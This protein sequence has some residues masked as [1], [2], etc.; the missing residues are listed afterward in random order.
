MAEVSA[1][2]ARERELYDRLVDSSPQSMM[3]CRRWWLDA[4]APN[5][6]KILAVGDDTAIRAAWPV[7]FQYVN[8]HRVIA[9]PP[10][11]QKLG[12][13]LA[14][15]NGKYADRLSQQH[16]DIEQ[17]VQQLPV[18]MFVGQHFHESFTN[19]LPFYWN[20]FQQTTRYTYIL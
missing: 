11:T 7:T 10:L 9:M 14:N 19:W 5:D 15:D 16:R 18:D 2:E 13:L 17:L 6:Y 4:V 1:A 3:Y 12:I 8:E 20:G